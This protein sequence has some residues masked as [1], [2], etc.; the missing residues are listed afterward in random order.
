MNNPLVSIIIPTYNRAHY[1]GETLESVIMQ[2]YQNWECIVIDDGS[3]DYTDELMEFYCEKDAKIQYRHRPNHKPKGANACRNYGIE[4]S[5]GDYLIFL[6]SDDLLH[7]VSI[8]TRVDIA[9]ANFT[10]NFLIFKM[11]VFHKF[12][13][14][15]NRIVNRYIEEGNSDSY[16]LMFLRHEIPWQITSLFIKKESLGIRFDEGLK[17]LQDVEFSSRLLLM[18]KTENFLVINNIAQDCFY[19]NEERHSNYS[20]S[21]LKVIVNS[22]ARYYQNLAP[23]LEKIKDEKTYNLYRGSLIKTFYHF[24]KNYFLLSNCIN[25]KELKELKQILLQEKFITR[26]DQMKFQLLEIIYFFG[27][28][29]IKGIGVYRLT[30]NWLE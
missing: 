19:R 14:D 10:K 24:Y 13:G 1:I 25:W 22:L 6:D 11:T 9:I 4:F 15:T 30:K 2:T 16:L 26:T 29:K 21:F 18:N 17:R 5:N 3:S 27:L 28:H 8:E 12:P 20:I 23:I 7:T